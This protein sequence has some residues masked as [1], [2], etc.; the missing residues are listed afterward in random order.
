M[1]LLRAQGL[2][3]TRGGVRLL[4]NLSF[5]VNPGEALILRGPNGIGKSSLLRCLAGLQPVF[6][7]TI[8]MG[9]DQIAYAAHADGLKSSLTVAENLLFW[10]Q[11]FGRKDI[12]AAL[13]A[14]HLTELSDRP[15][16]SLSA[17]QKRRLGLARLPVSGRRIWLLDEPTVSLDT[18]SIQQF[19]QLILAHLA[20]GG[21][22][23]VATHTDIGVP[24]ATLLDL[25]ACRATSAHHA[26]PA[27]FDEAFA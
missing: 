26:A 11:I 17:G 1:T 7:G 24:G 12:G 20:E 2:T 18:D 13:R 8:S 10:A 15:A 9:E 25:L 14:L 23:V 21:A 4:E 3:V 6:A 22:A 19:S 5:V 16:A 27:S